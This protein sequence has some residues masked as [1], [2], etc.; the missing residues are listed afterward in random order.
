[1]MNYP[2]HQIKRLKGL[3]IALI[4]LFIFGSACSA[5]TPTSVPTDSEP[6]PQV[7]VNTATPNPT[8]T[9]APS[10]TPTT[11]TLGSAGN[12]ITIGFILTPD[13]TIAK[14]SA[15]DIAF[16]LAEDTGYLIESA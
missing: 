3:L 9:S 8:A 7:E 15:E 1:M 6:T 10:P 16:I 14:E 13:E 12:P 2:I 4:L 11:P 5:D